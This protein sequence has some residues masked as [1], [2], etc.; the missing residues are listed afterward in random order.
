MRRPTGSSTPSKGS[1]RGSA[2][3][4]QMAGPCGHND[5]VLKKVIALLL[6]GFVVYYLLTTPQDAA[7][8]VSSGLDKLMDAFKQIGTFFD[9]LAG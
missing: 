4:S 6:V 9:A 3:L 5:R 2:R 1:W 7:D 8:A